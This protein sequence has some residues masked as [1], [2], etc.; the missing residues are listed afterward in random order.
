[1]VVVTFP[2][3]LMCAHH[4]SQVRERGSMCECVEIEKKRQ[5]HAV[6]WFEW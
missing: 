6:A 5:N 1:M 4:F 2:Q 3:R